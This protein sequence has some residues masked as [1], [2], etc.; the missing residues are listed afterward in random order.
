MFDLA[1][2]VTTRLS[3]PSLGPNEFLLVLI[4]T[5]SPVL[6]CVERGTKLLLTNAPTQE[7]PTPVWIL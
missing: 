3:Q 4:S 7:S 5:I 2:F 6:S 1:L